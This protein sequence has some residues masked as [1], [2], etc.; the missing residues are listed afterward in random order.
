VSYTT[1]KFL[2]KKNHKKSARDGNK[3]E[4]ELH[5]TKFS[6]VNG[7]GVQ[8]LCGSG[9]GFMIWGLGFWGLEFG[10]RSLGFRV[11]MVSSPKLH[12]QG[13]GFENFYVPQGSGSGV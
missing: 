6:E 7:L 10:T 2:E 11:Y 13:L 8:G 4:T 9:L 12:T 5:V 3:F 1:P